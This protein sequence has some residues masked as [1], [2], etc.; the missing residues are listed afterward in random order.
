MTKIMANFWFAH[1]AL[2]VFMQAAIAVGLVL[3]GISLWLAALIGA[4]AVILAYA[5]RERA[6]V[7]V[8][9]GRN[10]PLWDWRGNPKAAKDVGVP[11]ILVLIV[12]GLAALSN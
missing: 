11:A 2:A 3:L 7:E 12:A 1:G 6:Q 9:T 5:A 10:T 8:A 4:G